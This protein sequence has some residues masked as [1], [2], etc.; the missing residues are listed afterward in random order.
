VMMSKQGGLLVLVFFFLSTHLCFDTRTQP[1]RR[2]RK[3]S[4]YFAQ[5]TGYLAKNMYDINKNLFSWNSLKIITV[6]FPFFI[7]ARMIDEKLQNCFYDQKSHRNVYQIPAWCHDVARWSIGVP[8]A[9]LGMQ[10]FLSRDEDFRIT[11]QVFLAGVPFVMLGKKLIKKLRFDACLRP[12]NGKFD[13]NERSYGGL[14][15]GH[16]AEATYTAVLYGLRFGYKFAVPLGTLTAFVGISFLTCNRHYLS[17]LVAGA[18]FGALYAVA[19]S[20]TA[21][22]RLHENISFAVSANEKG[23][24][25]FGLSYRF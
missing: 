5:C 7:G 25:L 15:S 2:N 1:Y 16:V 10:S 19:A 3:P 11:S 20:K 8:I 14:P 21:D 17:Q 18:G 23:E 4:G 13:R 6:T 22:S 9:L 24:P 12:W